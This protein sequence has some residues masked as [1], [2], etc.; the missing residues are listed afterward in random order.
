VR[1]LHV[2]TARGWRG[3][4][5]QVLQTALGMAGRG[6]QVALACHSA[7][8]L[9][10]RASGAALRVHR[11][12]FQGD[13]S[14]LALVPLARLARR[15]R[16]E[17]L[18]LHDPHALLPGL[19]A[20]RAS[21][22]RAIAVRRVDFPLRGG[23][24]RAKYRA[25][26][27]VI[28]VSR[29]IRAVL[30]QGGLP[31]D[32]LRLV[33]EGVPDRPPLTGGRDALHALGVPPDALVV[34]NVAALVDHKDHATLLAAAERVVAAAPRSVFVILG[35]GPLRS[36][37]EA[38]A[39]AR[40]L[41]GR[42]LFAGFRSDLDRLIPAFDV[43]CLSSQMEGLGTSLLDAM[44]FARPIVATAAGGIPDAV[45]DG[46]TGR[47][48][49]PRDPAALAGALLELLGDEAA[50][51][52]CGQAGRRAFERAFTADRMVEATLD[53]CRRPR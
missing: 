16:A 20:A 24:S 18:L 36:E 50:R 35:D 30:E 46:V 40:G 25:C 4:Q 22:A 37:L 17:L 11:L 19:L 52:A 29:A 31:A 44:C 51:T 28:V 45:E 23:F 48:V 5:N 6:H 9:A 8:V 15:A 47:L 53:A 14:P 7:G 38:D 1:V 49:P 39:R 12:R 32:A 33:H 21:G 43:F 3:G 26:D 42:C 41:Q 27:A 34:G 2:D 13:L 10:E